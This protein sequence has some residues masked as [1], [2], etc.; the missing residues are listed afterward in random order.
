MGDMLNAKNNINDIITKYISSGYATHPPLALFKQIIAK[1]FLICAPRTDGSAD[2]IENNGW[3][4]Q[5]KK[6]DPADI[7]YD[8]ITGLNMFESTSISPGFDA[9]AVD[10]ASDERQKAKDS[11]YIIC[12]EVYDNTTDRSKI[13]FG[14]YTSQQRPDGL[15]FVGEDGKNYSVGQVKVVY[16]KNWMR[17]L[18]LLEAATKKTTN[19]TGASKS[20]EA[21][22]KWI[23]YGSYA[24]IN[25]ISNRATLNLRLPAYKDLANKL[26]D[27]LS[28][29]VPGNSD[30]FYGRMISIGLQ[31]ALGAQQFSSKVTATFDCVRDETDNEN[32]C[33]DFTMYK[34]N[35]NAKK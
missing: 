16:L 19:L 20:L 24:E 14:S 2:V 22:A 32:L 31:I 4:K 6:N 7:G 10:I 18:S 33:V 9:V 35:P 8:M 12:S 34:E 21:W 1:F 5:N 11:I 27:I 3:K 29:N 15:Y 28:F 30:K 17:H 25:R 26:G 23:A 13:I